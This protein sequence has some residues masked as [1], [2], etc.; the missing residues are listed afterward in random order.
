M[1]LIIKIFQINTFLFVLTLFRSF[2]YSG[3][4]TVSY[5]YY[6]YKIF[7][8]KHFLLLFSS[9]CFFVW[10]IV[11][12]RFCPPNS[13]YSFQAYF[14]QYLYICKEQTINSE[15][16]YLEYRMWWGSYIYLQELDLKICTLYAIA[17]LDENNYSS[18]W[19]KTWNVL[20]RY[21]II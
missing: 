20:F 12:Y 13:Y 9:L 21:N 2:P 14:I 3:G 18:R 6:Y 19:P 17:I 8:W 4:S 7:K 5:I 16:L 11:R 1:P 15:H 10:P